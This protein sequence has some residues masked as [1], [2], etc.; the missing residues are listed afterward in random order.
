MKTRKKERRKNSEK[1]E[2][3]SSQ[4]KGEIRNRRT[5]EVQGDACNILRV[6]NSRVTISLELQIKEV[7][8]LRETGSAR[9]IVRFPKVRANVNPSPAQARGT[10][11]GKIE[12]GKKKKGG[13]EKKKEKKEGKTPFCLLFIYF[14]YLNSCGISM[15]LLSSSSGR[16]YPKSKGESQTIE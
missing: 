11:R 15:R 7:E 12:N 6:V 5:K 13:K 10:R 16:K 14:L 2:L 9:E 1:N 3:D 4:P 8:H